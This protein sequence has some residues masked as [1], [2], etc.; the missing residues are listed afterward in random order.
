M[1][2]LL[3]RGL[4]KIEGRAELPG[5]PLLYSTTDL[6]LD[7]FGIRHLDDLPNAAELRRVKLPDAGGN[8]RRRRRR[9]RPGNRATLPL[10]I[11]EPPGNR[12]EWRN[13]RGIPD[14]F[15]SFQRARLVLNR[16]GS[17]AMSMSI[18][19]IRTKIDRVDRELLKL[20]SE[21]AELVHE[22]GEIK[23][24]EGLEIFAPDREEKLLR[25]LV[26]LNKQEQGPPPGK[27][28]PRHLPR[29]HQRRPGAGA[30]LAHRLSRTRRIVDPSGGDQPLRQQRA[31]S[32]GGQH[33]G[34]V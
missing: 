22:V 13:C 11:E 25:K 19:D 20:L 10:N 24:K 29:D 23:R 31:L 15:F 5:R 16:G 8:R 34:C 17:T 33:R 1:Q 14:A 27:I 7:H 30:G 28:P 6:F 4:V 12:L 3:D 26:E 2:Q 18:E 32:S 9:P 21:R